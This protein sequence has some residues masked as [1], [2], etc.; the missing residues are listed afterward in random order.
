MRN[1]WLSRSSPREDVWLMAAK[2]DAAQRHLRHSGG[3]ARSVSLGRVG[4]CDAFTPRSFINSAGDNIGRNTNPTLDLAISP[5]CLATKV[6]AGGYRRSAI[7][8]QTVE[9][10]I[11]TEDDKSR[12]PSRR[13]DLST[14]FSQ[15]ELVDT[16]DP[17]AH[18]NANALPQHDGGVPLACQR[19][20]DYARTTGGREQRTW[21]FVGKHDRSAS[22][23]R[24]R[25]AHRIE[26]CAQ[27]LLG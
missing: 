9:H 8:T 23:K 27:Q 4:C 16:S 25:S 11:S 2:T 14:F 5:P 20:R 10:N 19:F 12:Q 3:V 18:T 22:R 21:G 1:V 24:R 15:L 7:L 17:G 6:S 26:G 13:P